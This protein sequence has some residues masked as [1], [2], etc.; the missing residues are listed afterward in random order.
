MRPGFCADGGDESESGARIDDF[1]EQAARIRVGL[2][3]SPGPRYVPVLLGHN[4]ACT[5]ELQRSG[6]SCGGGRDPDNYCRTT[7]AAFEREFRR[8]MDELIRIP[9]ARILVLALIRI[10]QLCNLR[11][12]DTC[13]LLFGL[14]CRH[15]WTSSSQLGGIF[16]SGGV[17]ASLTSDCS[18]RRRIDMYETL[19]GYNEIL[20]R[21]A[22]EYA[23]I[24]AGGRSANGAVKAADVE[25]R[26]IDTPFQYKLH[27]DDLSCCDCFHPSEF[28]QQLLAQLTWDGLQ[29][30]DEMPC[31]AP[32]DDPLANARCDDADEMSL[33]PGSFWAG[34]VVCGNGVLDPDEECDDGN[35]TGGDGC[36]ADCLAEAVTPTATATKTPPPSFTPTRNTPTPGGPCAGDCDENGA[37]TID[38]VV[39]AVNIALGQ[40]SVDA[41]PAADLNASGEITINELIAAID[42]LL[43]G[44]R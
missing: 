12:M 3:F 42:R 9:S 21:V 18:D 24:P 8:G 19:V 34:G 41:C 15:F 31:C 6:N 44:C 17:C 27:S 26:F 13:G 33:L 11:R 23:A 5:N 37:V 20:E 22:A 36:S 1:Q 7:R 35:L 28:G 38:E 25:I 30:S 32:S 14:E 2:G 4:D 40:A 39:T 16:G 10:S 29:C 43:E